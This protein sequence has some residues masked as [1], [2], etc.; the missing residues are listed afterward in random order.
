MKNL[1]EELK[2]I[3]KMMGVLKEDTQEKCPCPDNTESVE[4]CGEC[5]CLNGSKS[6][7][8]CGGLQKAK[9]LSPSQISTPSSPEKISELPNDKK[10]T[11]D[12][13]GVPQD[14]LDA[15]A[16]YSINFPLEQA[17]FLAQCKVESDNFNATTEYASGKAYEGR[18][19]DLGNCSSGDGVKYKGRGY[20]QLTGKSN[21]VEYNK[22]LKEKYG[23]KDDV[24]ENPD[25]VATKYAGDVSAW[26]WSVLG[27]KYNKPFYSMALKGTSNEVIDKIGGWI[28]G[29]NPPNGYLERR[30]AFNDLTNK[31]DNDY[32]ASTK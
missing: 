2:R 5:K 24:V 9:T 6:W 13:T 4:C 19:E 28:N 15:M 31:N 11:V 3:K 16:D 30:E 17:H 27:P 29:K 25:L 7:N 10:I 1:L 32:L 8:C 22:W 23:T 20:V 21:Y 12:K 14:L 26:F 18:C